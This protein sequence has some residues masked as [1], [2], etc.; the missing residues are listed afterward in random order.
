MQVTV[1]GAR[2]EH[3]TA[4][5]DLLSVHLQVKDLVSRGSLVTGNPGTYMYLLF[6]LRIRAYE[7]VFVSVSV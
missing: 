1:T 3:A 6:L 7:L 4:P 5:T 2:E